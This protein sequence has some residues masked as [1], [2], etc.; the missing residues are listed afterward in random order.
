MDALRSLRHLLVV[1]LDSTWPT[2]TTTRSLIALGN[3]TALELCTALCHVWR[4]CVKEASLDQPDGCHADVDTTVL[5]T[6]RLWTCV[7][8]QQSLSPRG[9][10]ANSQS[11]HGRSRHVEAVTMPAFWMEPLQVE[12]IVS[13]IHA[14]LR[15]CGI[16]PMDDATSTIVSSGQEEKKEDWERSVSRRARIKPLPPALLLILEALVTLVVEWHSAWDGTA[17][18]Q[19]RAVTAVPLL[20]TPSTPFPYESLLDLVLLGGGYHDDWQSFLDETTTTQFGRLVDASSTILWHWAVAIPH[21]VAASPTVWHRIERVWQC[22][23]TVTTNDQ[24]STI[25]SRTNS[26]IQNVRLRILRHLSAAVGTMVASASDNHHGAAVARPHLDHASQLSEAKTQ[27]SKQNWLVPCLVQVLLHEDTDSSPNERRLDYANVRRRC[28]RSVRCLAS[29]DWGRS[30]L[31]HSSSSA[32]HTGEWTLG[33]VLV[34][35]LRHYPTAQDIDTRV[36]ACRTIMDIWPQSVAY[37]T[38]PESTMI[39]LGPTLETTL[40]QIIRD[41]AESDTDTEFDAATD[42]LVLAATQ[43]L[44]VVLRCSPWKRSAL[45]FGQAVFEQILAVL[46]ECVDQPVYHVGISEFLLELVRVEEGSSSSTAK[47][48]S[49]MEESSSPTMSTR[50]HGVT[51]LLVSYPCVLEIVC[52]LLAPLSVGPDYDVSRA[53]TVHVL[54]TIV[55]D[56][57][58]NCKPMA[59]DENLLS[60]LVNVCLL[61]SKESQLKD[62]AKQLI[63]ALVPEL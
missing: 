19:S 38:E 51:K 36:L 58:S 12:M 39:A 32:H 37:N 62:D 57:A 53:N 8:K 25:G 30:M 59:D 1:L 28:M 16:V 17:T 56:D 22:S 4:E 52:V 24:Q 11:S 14:T 31:H 55:R 54:S 2:L 40:L 5:A 44:T 7:W 60:A 9:H 27:I 15:R 35:V 29:T 43:A 49:I 41:A 6:I 47:N 26:T 13:V 18:A 42:K 21:T 61:S 20:L 46:L 23:V 50:I 45:V 63:F 10:A 48:A 3:E 33:S 34:H